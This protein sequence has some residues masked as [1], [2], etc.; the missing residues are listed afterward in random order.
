MG[1]R[2]HHGSAAIGVRDTD[3]ASTWWKASSSPRDARYPRSMVVVMLPGATD[4]QIRAVVD[5]VVAVGGEAFVSRGV[6]RTTAPRCDGPKRHS[7][8]AERANPKIVSC[9]AKS[10]GTRGMPRRAR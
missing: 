9:V 8:D 4:E 6:S 7:R 10:A 3:G 2:P 5:R 1:S